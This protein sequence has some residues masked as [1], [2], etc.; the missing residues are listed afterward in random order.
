[1]E[2]RSQLQAL[3]RVLEAIDTVSDWVGRLSAFLIPAM[4]LIMTWEV[5]A[6]H[7]LMQPTIWAMEISQYFFLATTVLGGGYLLLYG[8]HVNVTILYGRLNTRLRAIID[9]LTSIFF[10]FF[11][12]ALL[13]ST[14]IAMVESI[15]NREHSPTY[16]SPPIY[17]VYII[18]TLGIGLMS[19][20]GIAKV[21][22]DLMTAIAGSEK[23]SA[24]VTDTKQSQ[25]T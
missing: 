9:V 5:V 19:T 23:R 24:L 20:Q 2:T 16:W 17:P 6:R 10:F 1:M 25:D 4:M 21:V 18:M 8:G 15:V 7:V 12:L 3:K 13:Q 22:R 11:V 14:W